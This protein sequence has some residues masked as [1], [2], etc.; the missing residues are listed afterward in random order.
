MAR[1]KRG[2]VGGGGRPAPGPDGGAVAVPRWLPA[3][4]L[5]VTTLLL[6][7]EF[8]FSDRMLYGGDTL[9]LGYMARDFYATSLRNGVFPLWSPRIL[10]GI[11]FL[12]A[13]AA[14]DSLYPTALLLLVMP[15]YRAL[16]WKLVLHVFAAGLFMFG[17]VRS[18]GR[19]RAAALLSGLAYGVAPFL[20][21]LVHPGHDGKLFV[22]TLTPLLFWAMERTFT[23]SGLRA[24]VLVSVVVT[25]V[26]LTTHFQLAYFLFGAAGVYYVFRCW[27]MWRGAGEAGSDGPDGEGAVGGRGVPA[28]EE[29]DGGDGET[30]DRPAPR[31]PSPRPALTKLG[32]FLVASV[33]GASAAAVQLVPAFRYVGEF[34]RR[35]STTTAAG[36]AENRVYASSWGLHPEELMSY[37]VPEFAGN[38]AGGAAW[39]RSSYWGRNAFKDNHEY[40]GW[41]VLLLALVGFFGMPRRRLRWFLAVL[42]TLALLYALGQHTPVW[43]IAYALLPGVSLFRAPSMV[44]YLFG[45]SAVTLMAFGVDR[46]L[47]L[48]RGGAGKGKEKGTGALVTTLWAVTGVV[49]VGMLLAASGALFSFWTSV[50]YPDI[51]PFKMTLLQSQEPFIVRGFFGA[52]ALAALVAGVVV[53]ARKGVLKPLGV[54]AVL[55]VLVFL[56]GFRVSA[57]FIQTMDE[58]LH[59]DFYT[60]SQPDPLVRELLD[61]QAT[62][63][64]FRVASL[65]GQGQDVTPAMHG[66]EMATGHHPNDLARYRELIGMVGSSMPRN[67]LDPNVLAV[68][69]VR[70]LIW[71]DQAG[72]P[73]LPEGYGG[74]TLIARTR[75]GQQPYQSLYEFPT[76]PRARLV[77]SAR[78]VPDTEA[79]EVI[80]SPDFDPAAEAVLPEAPPLELDGGPV[81]GEVTWRQRG[82]NRMRLSVTSDRNALLVLADNWY[83]AWHATV[84]GEEVRVLRAYHTLRAVPVG[85]GE[86]VVEMF[87]ASSVL[88]GSLTLS[89]LTV[90]LLAGVATAST[91]RR[92]RGRTAEAG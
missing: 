16:G 29:G 84:D 36:P 32:L 28:G 37:V 57:P 17:W 6:F 13:L 58:A 10:G 18:L 4:L 42:G 91:L 33:L 3:V 61:R 64:P 44:S 89:L 68:L 40:A 47:E 1:R 25:L 80:R 15:T 51:Q 75:R 26:V 92:R 54:V 86:H 20:V 41:V 60:W 14:G 27:T 82:V 62:E 52:T 87:Y 81:A 78:V 77:A 74:S 65:E 56:D 90:L 31:G 67:I 7:R 34:S 21:T 43:G 23:R 48:A 39:A 49:G 69:N 5:G 83:P 70:Y 30:D 73:S 71:P 76:L 46:I 11:P 22:T 50:V 59:V 8:V 9:S 85:P 24:Y 38:D 88:K 79:V 12:D 53:A 2:T 72:L 55:G 63:P 66:L 19:S 45:F 35:T